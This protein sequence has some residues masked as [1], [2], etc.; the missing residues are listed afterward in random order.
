MLGNHDHQGKNCPCRFAGRV[1]VGD[2]GKITV[3]KG[4][5]LL[6]KGDVTHGQSRS[7]DDLRPERKG[8]K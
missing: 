7:N 1:T 3:Q 2:G 4:G 6:Q 8:K 5:D